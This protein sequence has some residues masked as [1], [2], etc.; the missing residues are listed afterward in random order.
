MNG[1]QRIAAA[2]AG[3]PADRVPVMLHNFMMAAREYGVTMARFRSDPHVIAAAFVASVERYGFDGIVVDVDTATLAGAV[4]VP[5]EFPDDLPARTRGGCL[6]L[7][8]AVADLEPADVAADSRIQTWL[9]AVRLVKAAVG[10]EIFVRGNC[11]QAPFALAA[12]ARGLEGWMT[13]LVTGREELVVRLLEHCT[14]ATTQFVRLMADTGCDMVSNGDS[15]AGPDLV[16]PATYERYALPFEARV[17]A[18]AHARG[19]PYALH[20]CGRTDL[21]LDRMTRSGADAFEL[22]HKTDA[23]AARLAF[24]GRATF[25]GNID[26]SGVLAL[27]SPDDVRRATRALLDAFEGS[28]RLVVNAG[29]AIPADTPAANLAAMVET[30]RGWA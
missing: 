3:E 19:L 20:I 1:R 9:E 22:D 5:V 14:D 12:M 27:A 16:S 21:I 6:A 11:D 30:A 23:A 25:I 15:P 26:P 29:C 24:D 13:D 8:E 4:G 10:D 18:A 2:L 28:N 17:V 7:L